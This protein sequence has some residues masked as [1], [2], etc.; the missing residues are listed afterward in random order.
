MA[1]GQSARQGKVSGL[2]HSSNSRSLHSA[3][4]GTPAPVG[5]TG[6]LFY[7]DPM[8]RYTATGSFFVASSCRNTYCKIPPF[9]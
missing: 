1:I 3:V 5:M 4:A 2:A 9:A 8:T 6:C 7:A